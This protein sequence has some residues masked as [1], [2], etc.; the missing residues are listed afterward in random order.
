MRRRWAVVLAVCSVLVLAGCGKPAGTDGDLINGWPAFPQAV[1]PVPAV[2][3]CYPTEYNETWYTDFSSAVPCSSSH[4]T[5]TVY[6]GAFTGADADRSSPPLGGSPSV[7]AAY[8]QCQQAGVDYLGG[9]WHAAKVELGLV[10]PDDK[11]WTGG[12]RWYRCDVTRFQDANFD[13]VE[14]GGGS[15]KDGLRGAKPLAVNCLV[16]TDDGKG[17]IK[18]TDD[19]TC[20][21]PHN[22]EFIGLYTAPDAAWQPDDKARGKIEDAGC[23]GVLST[24]LGYGGAKPYSNYVGWWS[25]GFLEDQWKLGD[26]TERCWAVAL[27][28]NGLSVN[29]VRVVGSMRGL[30]S[31]AP[32][33]P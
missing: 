26:R 19:V 12:A 28:G 23:E 32:K 6:V 30:R 24:F 31:G 15:A 25:W 7:R 21:K 8:Q 13:S 33:R 22:A 16:L 2:G 17:K 9:D 5:E 4:Q 27:T 11:A 1:T 3:A 29:G 20:D 18:K 10:L 14:S